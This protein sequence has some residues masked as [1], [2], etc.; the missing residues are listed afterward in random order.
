MRKIFKWFWNKVF[1]ITL[2]VLCIILGFK[3]HDL[4]LPVLAVHRIPSTV[5]VKNITEEGWTV[6]GSGVVYNETGL[7]LTAKHVVENGSLITVEFQNGDVC[8]AKAWFIDEKNDL[9]IIKIKP[10]SKLRPVK[11]NTNICVGQSVFIIGSPFGYDFFNSMNVGYISGLY[12]DGSFF[13]ESWM[14]QLDIAGNP[15]NSGCPV[16]NMNGQCIGIL[17]G[18][19]NG[20]DGINLI[21]P[22]EA[23]LEFIGEHY[24]VF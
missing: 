24:S 9:A 12:R 10:K 18:G 22:S 8:V 6:S 15:G 19:I 21:V 2:I 13:G 3:L 14:I 11:F 20:A 7:I 1:L 5:F 16:Y 17:V 4:R 23:I